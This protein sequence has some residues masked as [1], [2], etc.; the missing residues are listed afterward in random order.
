[1][2]GKP[3][4]EPKVVL[5]AKQRE[6]VLW[7]LGDKRHLLF[8]KIKD[9]VSKTDKNDARDDFLKW[10]AIK[11]I[12][13]TSW[14]KVKSQLDLWKAQYHKNQRERKNATGSAYK[15]LEKWEQYLANVEPEDPRFN[16]NKA[17]VHTSIF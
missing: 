13:Y 14:A 3:H 12:P 7:E 2:P 1:M 16:P 8:G 4:T 15:P 11:E 5:N 10:C 9:K 6:D 17:K